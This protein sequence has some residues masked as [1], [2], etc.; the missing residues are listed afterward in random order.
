MLD[1]GLMLMLIVGKNEFSMTLLGLQRLPH[2]NCG[3]FIAP[4]ICHFF[5]AFISD[6]NDYQQRGGRQGFGNQSNPRPNYSG[7]GSSNNYQGK[8]NNAP[9]P[10]SQSTQNQQRGY[11]PRPSFNQGGSSYQSNN[12]QQG[13]N[14][15]YTQWRSQQRGGGYQ[16]GNARGGSYQGN[17]RGGYQRFDSQQ[18]QPQ[19]YFAPRPDKLPG[20]A[21]NYGGSY[22]R[23]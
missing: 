19:R 3:E 9:P 23:K 16:G 12:P 21:N 10:Y 4:L 1:D 14:T 18:Q 2:L 13:G 15:G 20:Q 22:T 11:Q 8:Y 7:G 17:Q 6:R 5:L